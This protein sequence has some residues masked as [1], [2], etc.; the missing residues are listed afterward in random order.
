MR[1]RTILET[2]D[3]IAAASGHGAA[4]VFIRTAST[5][6]A[7]AVD[8]EWIETSPAVRIRALEGGHLPQWTE[9][10]ADHA[11]AKLPEPLRRAVLLGRYTGQRRGDLVGM[12]WSAYD[13]DTLRVHQ[14]KGKQS[15][16]SLII[17]VHRNLRVELDAWKRAATSTHILTT[18]TGIPWRPNHLTQ[19]MAL[20]LPKIGLRGELNVHGLRKL[21]ASSLAEAGCSTSEIAAITG[22]RTLAMVQLYTAAAD[23]ERLASSAIVRLQNAPGKRGKPLGK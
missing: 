21:A 2:R 23:Q 22:H 19:T 17:R 3:D 8:R 13:G 18:H 12:L 20:W 16:A 11:V 6:F 9:A 7:W 15:A 5:L 14:S 10:E 4:N 1:R